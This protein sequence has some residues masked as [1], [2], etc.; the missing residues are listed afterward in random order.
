MDLYE[1]L[2]KRRTIRDFSDKEEPDEVLRKI[3]SAAFKAPTID[4]LRQLEFV[5]VRD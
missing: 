3:L 2:E 4:H 5:V 1:A